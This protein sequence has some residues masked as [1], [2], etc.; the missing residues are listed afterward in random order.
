MCWIRCHQTFSFLCS[1]I[2][3]YHQRS[4]AIL[5]VGSPP[6]LTSSVLSPTSETTYIPCSTQNSA[7]VPFVLLYTV[8]ILPK[9]YIIIFLILSVH[10]CA[11]AK[12]NTWYDKP[13]NKIIISIEM[14]FGN[15]KAE[16]GLQ[17]L[18]DF[19]V[20]KSYIEG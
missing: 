5:A 10:N 20:D 12:Q 4:R 8:C 17:A 3:A 14:G 9:N 11:R 19:L 13:Q 1:A 7:H 16:A 18:N 2:E 6:P 15:L